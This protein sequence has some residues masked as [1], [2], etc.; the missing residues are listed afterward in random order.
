MGWMVNATPRPL[1]P[2]ERP[3]THCTGGWVD[4][5]ADLDRCGKSV[6]ICYRGPQCHCLIP[7]KFPN[8]I[9]ARGTITAADSPCCRTTQIVW[10]EFNEMRRRLTV[11]S[12][13]SV[14][15]V[16]R[17]VKRRFP[18]HQYRCFGATCCSILRARDVII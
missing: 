5:R 2:Q 16:S 4:P 1:Y 9:I 14:V 13:L 11:S 8:T 6:A 10:L 17:N 18:C 12:S 7:Y 15:A 3:G